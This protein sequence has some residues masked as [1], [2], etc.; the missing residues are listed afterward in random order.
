MS[1]L[2][3]VLPLQILGDPQGR[4][5]FALISSNIHDRE[6]I[7]FAQ[8]APDYCAFKYQIKRKWTFVVKV[9]P[10]NSLPLGSRDVH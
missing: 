6:L 10:E 8:G 5:K 9:A 3:L 4:E 1:S 2:P 7:L